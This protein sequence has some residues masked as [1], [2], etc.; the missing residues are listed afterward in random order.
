MLTSITASAWRAIPRTSP[1]V[2]PALVRSVIDA[3]VSPKDVVSDASRQL[4]SWTA[5]L[6]FVREHEW[7]RMGNPD[8]AVWVYE[9]GGE[10]GVQRIMFARRDGDMILDTMDPEWTQRIV[11][12]LHGRVQFNSGKRPR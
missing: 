10:E 5:G 11:V 6:D 2:D 8:S 7:R 12:D 1:M 9:V 3:G 4:S